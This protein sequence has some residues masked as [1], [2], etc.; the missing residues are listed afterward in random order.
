VA[1]AADDRATE[2]VQD[3]RTADCDTHTH[4]AE[5][6]TRDRELCRRR[7]QPRLFLLVPGLPPHVPRRA[8]P[9]ALPVGA[10]R[11]A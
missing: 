1:A 7:G 10:G 6:R 2:R 3:E 11:A 5:M 4:K 9:G 8:R